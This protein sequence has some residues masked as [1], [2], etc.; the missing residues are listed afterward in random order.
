MH[1][2]PPSVVLEKE[3][4]EGVK[5]KRNANHILQ[6]VRQLAKR[7]CLSMSEATMWLKHLDDVRLRRQRGAQKAVA[8]T[9]AKK[10]K[11]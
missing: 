5:A 1:T 2:D 8:T 11:C 6:G 10:Y 9:A 4:T 7:T 3:C